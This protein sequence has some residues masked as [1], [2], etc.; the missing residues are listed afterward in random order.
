VGAK[1]LSQYC[2]EVEASARRGD[3]GEAASIVAKLE[4]EHGRVQAALRE[5]FDQLKTPVRL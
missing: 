4:V 5:E 2:A 1:V 3:A